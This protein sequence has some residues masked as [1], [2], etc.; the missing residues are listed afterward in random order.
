MNQS[1]LPG[2]GDLGNGF[3]RN[4]VLM[5]DYSDPDVIRVG[6]DFYMICS[7]FHFMGMPV[8]HST[9]LVNWRIIGQVYDALRMAPGYD[10]ME[11]YAKGSWAPALRYHNGTYHVYFCTP[12]EGLYMSTATHPAGPW[13]PLHEVCRVA[14]WE[15]P[16]PFW[17]EDGTAWLGHSTLGAGPIVIHRMAPDGR[18]LLDDGRIVYVG[19][20]A[21]GTKIYKREGWYYLVIPEGG[22]QVGWQT[23]LRSHSLLGPYEK[24]V[25]LQTGATGVNGPHQ[26][27]LVE[28]ENGETW[29]M[30]FQSRGALGRVCHLQPVAWEDG[31]PVMGCVGEPVSLWRKPA[32][33]AP[34]EPF[35]PQTD[36]GFATGLP[37]L[38][39]QCNHNPVPIS[40]AP[41]PIP[42]RL[43]RYALQ[44]DDLPRARNTLTQ[45]LMGDRGRISVWLDP[46]G[47][48]DGQ[49][50]GLAFLAGREENWIGLVC[51]AEGLRLE[52]VTAGEHH[53]GPIL[54]KNQI[55]LVAEIDLNGET[56]FLVSLDGQAFMRL[57]GTCR[58]TDGFWKGARPAL[59]SF[60]R[61]ADDGRADFLDFRYEIHR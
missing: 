32:V 27:A 1:I 7:E 59:F 56:C 54:E 26:G 41:A 23:V 40:G 47:M 35:L 57:G 43:C 6:E 38:Q 37:G 34:S 15:D 5:A 42:G 45:K 31:W 33:A 36:D 52:A 2:W 28:L 61:L 29:F 13:S 55:A 53:H 8:L 11:A 16:C 51:T 17:D 10:R 30:H 50:A 21:E 19:K 58:L 22:V 39:W 14:G 18:S 9:D 3:F 46:A 12:E 4:P 20:V 24:R 48:V 44:A 25:T 60:N 49:A